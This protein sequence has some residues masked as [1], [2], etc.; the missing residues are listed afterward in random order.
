MNRLDKA[1]LVYCQ[2]KRELA[3]Q[4]GYSFH[5]TSAEYGFKSGFALALEVMKEKYNLARIRIRNLEA[6]YNLIN[7]VQ[8]WSEE[9]DEG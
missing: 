6:E 8:Q 2:G 7:D 5:E 9:D 4:Y 3:D 1:A